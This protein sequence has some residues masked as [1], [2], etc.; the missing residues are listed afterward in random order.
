MDENTVAGL[1][2]GADKFESGIDDLFW[3]ICGIGSIDKVEDKPV[4]PP[5]D[6]IFRMIFRGGP[7]SVS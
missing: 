6:E 1:E 5:C 2:A 3:D 7:G 4:S